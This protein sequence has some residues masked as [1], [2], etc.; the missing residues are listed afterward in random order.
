MKRIA[1]LIAD[2]YD[3]KEL[4]Y[5]HIRL[6]EAGY[7][8]DLIGAEKGKPYASKHGLSSISDEAAKDIKADDYDALVIPGG[9]APDYMRR[10]QAMIDFV[11]AMDAQKK[12]I[13]A[14]CHGPWMMISG[15]DLKN[16]RL[17]G[18]FSIKDDLVNAGATYVDQAVV[19]DGHYITSRTPKDLPDFL[20]AILHALQ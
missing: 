19:I 11:K 3:D 12:P 10:S 7:Q 20:Q 15:C 2:L 9:F 1:M 8:V 16:R 17:T 13:A 4:I 18:F 14:I 6:Q 5:P